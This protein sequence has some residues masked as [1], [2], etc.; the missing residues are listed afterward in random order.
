MKRQ[1]FLLILKRKHDTD[2]GGDGRNYE[3]VTIGFDNPSLR[4]RRQQSSSWLLLILII[5]IR[6]NMDDELKVKQL[7][8][9]QQ[10]STNSGKLVFPFSSLVE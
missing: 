8:G 4:L 2:A 9:Y 6:Q 10:F 1:E 5:C 7:T 3:T